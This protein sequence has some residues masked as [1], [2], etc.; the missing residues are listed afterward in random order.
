M[1]PPA[2]LITMR[3]SA[4]ARFDCAADLLTVMMMRLYVDLDQGKMPI[5]PCDAKGSRKTGRGRA[6]SDEY[7][8]EFRT[9][10]APNE[11]SLQPALGCSQSRSLLRPS[12]QHRSAEQTIRT[13]PFPHR[14]LQAASLFESG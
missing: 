13:L 5:A 3:S 8:I 6:H 12:H 2:P 10:A 7:R 1:K 9:S 11:T 4:L 14:F